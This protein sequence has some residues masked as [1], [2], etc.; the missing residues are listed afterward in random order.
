MKQP[1]S[2]IFD[3]FSADEW[4]MLLE[5]TLQ[6][7]PLDEVT[8][9]R[10][11]ATVLARMPKTKRP[12]PRR[13]LILAACL[14]LLFTLGFGAYAEVREYNAAIRFFDEY[15]LSTVGLSRGEIK[16]VF[17]DIT[18][19]SFSYSITAE[20][21]RRSLS[22]DEVAGYEIPQKDPTPED[23]ENLWNYKNGAGP[24]VP[25]GVH[26]EYHSDYKLDEHLGFTVHDK[27]YFEKYDGDTLLWSVTFSEFWISGYEP[28]SD[29]VIVYGNTPTHSSRQTDYAWMMKIDDKGDICWK[30]KL[31]NGFGDE[32][33][34]AILENEDGTYAVISRGDL[35]YLCLSQYTAAGKVTHFCNTEVGNYGIWNA[36]R[37]GDGYLVQ[38]SS[39]ETME[40]ARIVKVDRAG[41]ITDS[42]SYA[43]AESDYF[44]TDMIEFEGKIY[45][46][47]YAVPKLPAEYTYE[48]YWIY[49]QL[50]DVWDITSEVL[51]PVVRD[52]YTAMLLVCDPKTGTPQAFYSVKGSLGGELALGEKGTLLWDVESIVTT[53]FHPLVSSFPLQ[54]TCHVYRYTFAPNGTLLRQEKTGEL[55]PFAR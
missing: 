17:R 54:G 13:I 26:Y 43:D 45:L 31:D 44:L 4:D 12:H 29:G 14:I 47:A 18:T 49:N 10:I 48:T 19:G 55:A 23:I 51:T 50:G 11:G 1:I 38:L 24:F 36:A 40:H 8:K 37:F 28:V 30:H 6:T 41:H 27:S 9:A 52:N 32:Y 33:I 3:K 15:D 5:E 22:T 39:Y 21:I 7:E 53:S 16:A 34:A 42:F 2:D 35:K 20:V 46:S 25:K